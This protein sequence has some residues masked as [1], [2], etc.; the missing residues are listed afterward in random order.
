MNDKVKIMIKN[1]VEENAVGFKNSTSGALYDKISNR[2]KDQ[3]KETAK[4]LFN[5]GNLK[6]DVSIAMGDPVV[7]A[8][9][10]QMTPTANF[11]ATKPPP[12]GAGQGAPPTERP[13]PDYTIDEWVK[14][15]PIP[16]KKDF[17]SEEQWREALKTWYEQFT[18]LQQL[19]R[20]Y[21]RS[22]G[23]QNRAPRIQTWEEYYKDQNKKQ[24][25]PGRWLPPGK[26]GTEQQGPPA[27]PPVAPSPPPG[28][29]RT[30]QYGPP[31]PPRKP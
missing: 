23:Q 21:F 29:P 2:L 17:P 31:A 28:T 8:E 18:K 14:S 1:V 22:I 20:F 5:K 25:T 24:K 6:E 13:K 30:R 10:A 15:N 26:P 27:P 12:G 3:Y 4:N 11:A 9:T 19:W 7:S 16:Q